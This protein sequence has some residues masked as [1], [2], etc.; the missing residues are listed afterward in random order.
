M[1]HSLRVRLKG[2][3]DKGILTSK[4]YTRLST[5]L[6]IEKENNMIELKERTTTVTCETCTH[7]NV[8]RYKAEAQ[9]FVIENVPDF[10]KVTVHCINYKCATIDPIKIN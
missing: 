5:L 8:C 3:T 10:L 6:D 9:E 2:L 4:D 7:K 1:P